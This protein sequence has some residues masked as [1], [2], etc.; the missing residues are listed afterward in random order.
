MTTHPAQPTTTENFDVVAYYD[1][2]IGV[3]LEAFRRA[4]VEHTPT[5]Q[6]RAY[7]RQHLAGPIG[8]LETI[9]QALK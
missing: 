9:R 2:Y 1:E 6:S 7:W 3:V 8:A 5:P 4:M